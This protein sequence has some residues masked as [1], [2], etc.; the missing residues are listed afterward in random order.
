MESIGCPENWSNWLSLG[1]SVNAEIVKLMSFWN[2]YMKYVLLVMISCIYVSILIVILATASKM[3]MS[4]YTKYLKN[5]CKK[6]NQ[7]PIHFSAILY[8]IM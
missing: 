1:F 5:I 3:S 7:Y 6:N 4:T 2:D 8:W